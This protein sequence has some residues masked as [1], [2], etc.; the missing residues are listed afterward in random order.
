MKPGQI[1]VLNGGYLTAFVV[2][3]GS[4]APKKNPMPQKSV[5]AIQTIDYQFSSCRTGRSKHRKTC[6]VIAHK[7]NPRPETNRKSP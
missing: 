5:L 1:S 4:A 7:P 3:T 6:K 2:G